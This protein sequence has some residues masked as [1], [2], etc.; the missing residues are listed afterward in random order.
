MLDPKHDADQAEATLRSMIKDKPKDPIRW[1][2]LIVFQAA[3]R[4]PAAV[5]STID[6]GP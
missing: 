5:A 4:T 6:S 2:S 1:L 3:R